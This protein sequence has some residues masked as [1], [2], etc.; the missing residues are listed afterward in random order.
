MSIPTTR[1]YIEA[2]KAVSTC[3]SNRIRAVLDLLAQAG[4]KLTYADDNMNLSLITDDDIREQ[5][6]RD[7]E[8]RYKGIWLKTDD[9]VTLAIRSAYL[10][11]Y[12]ITDIAVA[13]GV[14]RTALYEY[15]KGYR[16]YTKLT[17]LKFEAAFTNLNIPYQPAPFTAED[18]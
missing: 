13:A 12:K 9:P 2:A 11:G 17:R 16:N 3:N 1:D 7:R 10:N 6:K 14:S 8:E 5:R 4:I 18:I 15:M